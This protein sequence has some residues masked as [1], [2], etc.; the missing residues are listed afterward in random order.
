MFYN[1]QD[2]EIKIKTWYDAHTHMHMYV[3]TQS[4]LEDIISL[5]A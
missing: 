5:E 4:Q 3:Y 1:H 2:F